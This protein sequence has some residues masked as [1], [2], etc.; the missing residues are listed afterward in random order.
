MAT[1]RRYSL[2]PGPPPGSA[3]PSIGCAIAIVMSIMS[4]SHAQPLSLGRCCSLQ[5]QLQLLR[6][7]TEQSFQHSRAEQLH[8]LCGNF[9]PS[10]AP[11]GVPCSHSCRV[12]CCRTPDRPMIAVLLYAAGSS[13]RLTWAWWASMCQSQCHCRESPGRGCHCLPCLMMPCCRCL[14]WHMLSC[15]RCHN[16]LASTL[17]CGGG[18]VQVLLVHRCV[19]CL[20]HACKHAVCT[21]YTCMCCVSCCVPRDRAV[22]AA[23]WRGSFG[24]DL[25]MY[26]KAGVHFF[27]QVRASSI[28]AH[29]IIQQRVCCHAA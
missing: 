21:V 22:G 26:G 23:G 7:F 24:G 15:C 4:M 25:H 10:A 18:A 9:S 11:A 12:C 28:P 27:T 14:S 5:L 20:C 3:L 6:C 1:A 13:R 17:T 8:A 19:S 29:S 2:V 16:Y